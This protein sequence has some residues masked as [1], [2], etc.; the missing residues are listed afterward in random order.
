[1]LWNLDY[2]IQKNKANGRHF[3]DGFW[4]TYN[5][6]GAFVELFPFWSTKQIRRILTKLESAGVLRTGNYNNTARDRT[7]WYAIDYDALYANGGTDLEPDGD[8]SQTDK[9]SCPDG[10]MHLPKRANGDAQ[11]GKCIIGT[12]DYP[13]NYP[14]EEM[15]VARAG[16]TPRTTME[17]KCLFADSRFSDFG[18]FR[19]FFEDAERAG[20][21]VRYYF[22]AIAD[23]SSGGLNRKADWI[24]TARNWMR[25]DKQDG[26]LVMVKVPQGGLDAERLRY[27]NM[28]FE[29]D[30]L[31]PER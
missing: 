22:D 15:R 27:L 1:M 7:V 19:G 13:N 14:N 16:R 11:T 9:C 26:K 23:W 30:S 21:D 8:D 17:P 20:V 3:H 28:G 2:W 18:V 6:L 31:W 5:T 29:G 4:W 10:Q 12:T 24:A 25:R